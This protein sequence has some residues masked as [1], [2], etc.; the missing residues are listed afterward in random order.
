MNS[1]K[2]VYLVQQF[3][4]PSDKVQ[5]VLR[6]TRFSSNAVHGRFLKRVPFQWWPDFLGESA[7]WYRREVKK[8][9]QISLNDGH[10][11][12]LVYI[13]MPRLPDDKSL[14]E[15]YFDH[16]KNMLVAKKYA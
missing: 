6:R 9:S 8:N 3:W 4:E 12:H 14:N 7:D 11:D 2:V 5:R 1:N 15:I 16:E 13:K 10:I